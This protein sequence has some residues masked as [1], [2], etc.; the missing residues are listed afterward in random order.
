MSSKSLFLYVF[1]DYTA[2]YWSKFSR[3]FKRNYDSGQA[4]RLAPDMEGL[5][6]DQNSWKKKNIYD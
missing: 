6:D 4:E 1:L 5:I 3:F 2:D